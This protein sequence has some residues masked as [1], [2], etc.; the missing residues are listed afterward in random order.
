MVETLA[1]LRRERPASEFYEIRGTHFR[2]CIRAGCAR[3]GVRSAAGRATERCRCGS[4]SSIRLLR[5]DA[6]GVTS[7]SSNGSGPPSSGMEKTP[8]VSVV[9]EVRNGFC[10]FGT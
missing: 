10:D 2:V 9:G 7:E 1:G 4:C 6:A 5:T 8:R 3:C